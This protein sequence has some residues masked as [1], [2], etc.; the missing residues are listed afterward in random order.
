MQRPILCFS[1]SIYRLPIHG[2][3]NSS[4]P[5]L[6]TPDLLLRTYE[7]PS[8]SHFFTI[9]SARRLIAYY[10]SRLY[11]RNTQSIAALHQSVRT[12]RNSFPSS[13]KSSP[14]IHVTLKSMLFFTSSST[15]RLIWPIRLLCT[16]ATPSLSLHFANQSG[17]DPRNAHFIGFPRELAGI[18]S[19][20]RATLDISRPHCATSVCEQI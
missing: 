12:R 9:I 16:N 20:K 7:T 19:T 13:A 15:Q 14:R 6:A 18:A 2:T 3:P 8:F 1:S 4:L 10:S 5:I 17:F 11:P